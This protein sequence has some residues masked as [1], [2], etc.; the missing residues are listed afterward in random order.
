[1][2][3]SPTPWIALVIGNTRLHWA[4]GTGRTLARFWHTPHLSEEAIATLVTHH[5]D[6]SVLNKGWGDQH[7]LSIL[8]RSSDL[9]LSAPPSLNLQF[10]LA[11]VVP[12]QTTIWLAY[13]PQARLVTLDNLPLKNTYPTLGID[14]ALAAYGCVVRYG[15]AAL[16][17]DAGTAFTFTGIDAGQ[18]L[19]GGA[20]LPGVRLQ[21]QSLGTQTASLP[22]LAVTSFERLVLPDRWAL[23]T[24]S[25]ILSGVMYTLV[26]GVQGF[27]KDWRDRYPDSILVLTGGDRQI[28]ADG[29]QQIAPDIAQHL[30][31]SDTVVM[32]GLCYWAIENWET[33][34]EP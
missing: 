4:Q 6:F 22:H 25:A 7:S 33:E 24:Q 1:M 17:M 19:I 5:F 21:F 8:D 2:T 27:V 15:K 34:A 26:S 31:I 13:C 23:E 16:V 20:I 12:E 3:R 18:R 29:L 28:I 11:S 32:E 9:V 14:R 30:Q 10:I